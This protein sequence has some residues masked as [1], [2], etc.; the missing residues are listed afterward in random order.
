MSLLS[1]R[2]STVSFFP[3]NK[4]KAS[5]CHQP[6]IFIPLYST[7]A[8]CYQHRVPRYLDRQV[9]GEGQKLAKC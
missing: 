1:N 2:Y 3:S 5:H 4:A 9:V 7:Q 6:S 8:L